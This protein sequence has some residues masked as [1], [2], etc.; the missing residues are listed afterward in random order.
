MRGERLSR[1]DRRQRKRDMWRLLSGQK[2][3]DDAANADELFD[4][5]REFA[6]RKHVGPSLT[7]VQLGCVSQKIASH[8]QAT[9][10]RAG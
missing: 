10:A 6:E 4:K 5:S 2:I 9:A 8:P 1:V 7:H 3:N